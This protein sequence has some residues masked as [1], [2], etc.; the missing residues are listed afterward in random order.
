MEYLDKVITNN[1]VLEKTIL[2]KSNLKKIK[3]Y[4]EKMKALDYKIPSALMRAIELIMFKE[5][6]LLKQWHLRT[7][8]QISCKI[9]AQIHSNK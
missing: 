7:K 2:K 8:T 3:I 9:K 5:V 1:T 6:V 4:L